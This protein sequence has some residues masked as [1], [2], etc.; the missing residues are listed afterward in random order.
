MILGF[1]LLKYLLFFYIL[2]QSAF[3]KTPND[4]LRGT[5]RYI[6]K[7]QGRIICCFT[8]SFWVTTIVNTSYGTFGISGLGDGVLISISVLLIVLE[9]LLSFLLE[10]QFC[11]LMPTKQYLAAKNFD[12]Q[13]LTLLQKLVLQLIQVFT[14]DNVSAS[15][16]VCILFNMTLSFIREYRFFTTLPL[17]SHKSLLYQGNLLAIVL[18]L[19]WSHFFQQVLLDSEYKKEIDFRFLITFQP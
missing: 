17:Y 9:Y 12:M 5:W 2:V 1:T 19:H 11:D 10:T 14:D 8:T 13:I 4:F 18:A 15:L 16:W 6:F 3:N 7:L